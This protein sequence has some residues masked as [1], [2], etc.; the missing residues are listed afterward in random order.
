VL[1]RLHLQFQQPVTFDFRRSRPTL[2]RLELSTV[3]RVRTCLST[4]SSPTRLRVPT[5]VSRFHFLAKASA[6]KLRLERFR[7]SHARVQW[8]LLLLLR[9]ARGNIGWSC[10]YP[11]QIADSLWMKVEKHVPCFGLHIYRCAFKCQRPNFIQK[12]SLRVTVLKHKSGAN[13][14]SQWTSAV[15]NDS[16]PRFTAPEC[17][18][19][20]SSRQYG[21]M[22]VRLTRTVCLQK[23]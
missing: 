16:V 19:T 20:I 21:C 9:R 18:F 3:S 23:I 17:G 8:N 5:G 1:A 14:R 10:D 4:Y 6:L 15:N 12:T 2:F 13:H 7:T 11:V 22:G